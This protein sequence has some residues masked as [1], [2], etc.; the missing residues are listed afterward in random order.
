MDDDTA[1][2]TALSIEYARKLDSRIRADDHRGVADLV[3]EARA[4]LTVPSDGDDA[5]ETVAA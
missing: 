1:R 4:E 2:R 5:P 3:D